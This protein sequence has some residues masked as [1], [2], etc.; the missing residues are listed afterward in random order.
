MFLY[1]M[2]GV[3]AVGA[4]G[5]L[6]A[7]ALL[8]GFGEGNEQIEDRL[9]SLTKNGGRGVAGSGKASSGE[10]NSLL[11]DEANG[12]IDQYL[13]KLQLGTFID[14]AGLN[15][16]VSKFV[17]LSLVFGAVAGVACFFLPGAFKLAAR[18]QH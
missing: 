8:L 10:I 9:A 3:I 4:A 7:A 13:K 6:Y 14:Q 15:W 5:S 11:R 12:A 2:I 18:P 1:I 17:T 16:S